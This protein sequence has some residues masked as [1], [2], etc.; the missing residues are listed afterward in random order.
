MMVVVVTVRVAIAGRMSAMV[1]GVSAVVHLYVVGASRSRGE[2]A[3][4][5]L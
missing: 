4:S 5:G 3:S 1:V 2:G